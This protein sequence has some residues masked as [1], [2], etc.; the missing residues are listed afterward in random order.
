MD[1]LLDYYPTIVNL[2]GKLSFQ[3]LK[4]LSRVSTGWWEVSDSFVVSRALLNINKQNEVQFLRKYKHVKVFDVKLSEVLSRLPECTEE[5]KLVFSEISPSDFKHL[6]KLK[7]L[8]SLSF[9]NCYLPEETPNPAEL[10]LGLHSLEITLNQER[11]FTFFQELIRANEWIEN[12]SFEFGHNIKN[13]EPFKEL[14]RNIH[15]SNLEKISIKPMIHMRLK[16]ELI[17]FIRNHSN[18]K[19]CSLLSL[20][21]NDRVIKTLRESCGHLERL[22]LESCQIYEL[23]TSDVAVKELKLMRGL[24]HLDLTYTNFHVDYLETFNPKH[25]ESLGLGCIPLASVKTRPIL[26]SMKN[27]RV[28]DLSQFDPATAGFPD[29]GPVLDSSI[30]PFVAEQMPYI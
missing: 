26:H 4:S 27:I 11:H 13:K 9:Y 5:L 22:S 14:L 2:C 16:D 24:K 30:L 7:N 12:L 15:L 29:D 8:K 25:L 18:I 28:L 10:V 21:I 19:D 6:Q 1:S 20:V 23:E 17:D 3:E